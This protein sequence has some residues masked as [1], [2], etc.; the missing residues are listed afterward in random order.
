MPYCPNCG[1]ELPPDSG[2]LCADCALTVN[3]A[4]LTSAEITKKMNRGKPN[5]ANAP[6]GL[7]RRAFNKSYSEGARSCTGAAIV[8]Y[9]SAGT[10]LLI[11]LSGM[12]DGSILMLVD[13]AIVLTFTLLVHLLKS[14]IGAIGLLAYG[15]FNFIGY[16]V[17]SGELRGWLIVVAGVVAVIGAFKCAKEWR[18]YQ[19]RTASAAE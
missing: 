1:K 5:P 4:P 13:V 19:A 8:G 3:S 16:L 18:E 2:N 14:R 17:D 10:T 15:L 6:A 12:L 11:A 9:I 7:D